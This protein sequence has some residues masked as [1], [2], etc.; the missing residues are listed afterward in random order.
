MKILWA[1]DAFDDLPELQKK[2]DHLLRAVGKLTPIEVDPV[3]VLSPEQ[4]GVTLEFS[5]H[6]TRKYA[7][8]ARKSLTSKLDKSAMAA[9]IDAIAK[10][11]TNPSITFKNHTLIYL[12]Q[13]NSSL[14]S[15]QF[16]IIL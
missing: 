7:P 4:L 13:E 3:Y 8:L 1:V 2:T 10:N 11:R 16:S 14:R 6:W 5:E 15:Y 9:K 12:P